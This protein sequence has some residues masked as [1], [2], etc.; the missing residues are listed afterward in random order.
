MNKDKECLV[1]K[2]G[3]TIKKI[4]PEV[5]CQME[6]YWPRY[7]TGKHDDLTISALAISQN[8][9]IMSVDLIAIP[10]YRVDRI[11]RK[12]KEK[13]SIDPNRIIISAIHTHSGPTVTDLL[14]NYPEINEKYW[15]LIDNQALNAVKDALAN[16]NE[17]SLELISY[18]I[19]NGV[20][21]NRNNKSLPYNKNIYEFRFTQASKII[22]SYLLVA[23]HPTVM[24]IKNTLLSADLITEF[25]K[26]YANLHGITPIIAL[27]DCADT[28]T[29]FT[30]KESTF[31][32]IERLG[33]L[34]GQSL[35]NPIKTQQLVWNLES[36]KSVQQSCN[37]NPI[38]NPKANAI[39]EEIQRRYTEAKTPEDK[40]SQ[41]GLLRTYQ[42]IRYFGHTHFTTHAMIYDFK[43][44][45]IVTYPGELVYA[46]GNKIRTFDNK[47]TLL[48]TLANDYR[49][50]SVDEAEF[51]KY[52]ES[53]NS[54][55]LKGMADHFV[56]KIISTF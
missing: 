30:R 5:G 21:A 44:F 51:G 24:N 52:F 7:S 8:F 42:H 35:A 20:Y 38:T 41:E 16:Q 22:A 4:N 40:E 13:F 32:E 25:R 56:R 36:I 28:S 31:K 15:K 19:K 45:R 1:M 48:I 49:G 53:Y 10:G 18:Q 33:K 34:I 46:L 55:F 9:L 39:Y 47:P 43:E 37:Y 14:I 12:I 2:V 23:T 50:Y 6:G 27:S 17:A 26:Q 54:V 3:F 11:K 29:R